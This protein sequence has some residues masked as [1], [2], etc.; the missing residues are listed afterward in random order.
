MQY[1]HDHGLFGRR[2]HIP[3]GNEIRI[4]ITGYCSHPDLECDIDEWLYTV[5]ADF[6]LDDQRTTCRYQGLLK[7]GPEDFEDLHLFPLSVVRKMVQ[8]MGRGSG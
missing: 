8:L 2:K 1:D 3:T 4:R 5:E 7:A 6:P